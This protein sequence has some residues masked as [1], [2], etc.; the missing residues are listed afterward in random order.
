[1]FILPYGDDRSLG[2]KPMNCPGHMLLFGSQLRS[3]RE[4]PLRYAESSTLH[5]DERGGTLH[6]L[7]RVKHITQDDAHVFVSEDQIQDE[8]DAMIDF[9]SFLY[10]RFG[11]TPRAE[12]S[13]RPEK[14]LGTDEQWDNAEH[15]LEEALKR[16]GMGYVIS[17]GEGVFYGPKIDLHMT[18]VLGR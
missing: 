9:V 11:V 12:L 18:D 3:Y 2:L 7:L 14:R 4:L 13:T 5:R 15:A 8:I 6:G 17:P 1:M 16:H 10:D